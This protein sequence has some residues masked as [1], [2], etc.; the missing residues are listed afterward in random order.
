M[1]RVVG[2]LPG[3]QVALRI[4]AVCRLDLQIIVVVDV[5]VGAGI[6]FTGG[7]HLMR[8]GER[9]TGSRMVE[10]RGGP[11]NGIVARR[12]GGHWEDRGRCGMLWVAGLLP[13]GQ[14]ALRIAAIDSRNLQ[15]IVA[16][17]VTVLA[18]N[19]G[20]AVGQRE[21]DG[22]SG[23]IDRGPEPTVEI[24]A[25]LASGRELRR[26]VVRIRRFLKIGLVAG[27]TSRGKTLKLSNGGALVTV[28]A[29]HGGV[30][31]QQRKTVLV[32]LHLLDRDVPALHRVTLRAIGPHLALVYVF[33]AVLTVFPNVGENG[34]YVT[35]CALHFFVHSAQRVLRFIVIEFR[36]GSDRSPGR[37]RVTVFARNRQRA[38]RTPGI[39]VLI[40]WQRRPQGRH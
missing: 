5:A 12:A 26:N 4:A 20:V 40:V 2:L 3:R 25:A 15:R 16:A 30:R 17:H 37:C 28:I 10:I 6:D 29:L 21:I 34:L 8:L 35:L 38:M 1:D 13:G 36:N 27:N 24:V 23:V 32:I 33:V 31:T 19:I 39:A 14:M 11:G 7:R 9:K 22:R 18:R